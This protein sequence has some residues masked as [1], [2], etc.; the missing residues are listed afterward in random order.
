MFKVQINRRP[1]GKYATVMT[2][3]YDPRVG[4]LRVLNPQ[5]SN[6]RVI[7]PTGTIVKIK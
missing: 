3:P 6:I 2:T 1:R 4:D 7:T 5:A